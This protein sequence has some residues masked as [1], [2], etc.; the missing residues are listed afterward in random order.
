MGLLSR[1]IA[2]M[3]DLS[4]SISMGVK[5]IVISDN[6]KTEKI[7]GITTTLVCGILIGLFSTVIGL[8]KGIVN[9]YKKYKRSFSK[10]LQKG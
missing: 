8:G 9:E 3:M 6:T 10:E 4:I 1:Y 5:T 2:A 7:I